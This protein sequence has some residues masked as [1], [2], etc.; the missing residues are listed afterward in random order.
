MTGDYE[1]RT[2]SVEI[3]AEG[4]PAEEPVIQGTAAVY[5]SPSELL[6]GQF[7]EVIE[8]GFFRVLVGVKFRP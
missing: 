5:N 8:P 7:I 1:L 6:F 2:F 4:D 3:R